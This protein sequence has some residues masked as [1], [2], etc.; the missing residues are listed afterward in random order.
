MSERNTVLCNIAMLDMRRADAD[1]LGQIKRIENAALLVMNESTDLSG[2]ELLNC[3]TTVR[4]PDGA[5]LRQVNGDATVSAGDE[6]SDVY[7]MVNG[8]LMINPDVT[9]EMVRSRYVGMMVNGQVMCPR[10]VGAAL[11]A[12]GARVNGQTR[13]YPDGAILR[14]GERFEL[15]AD[16]AR[17]MEP[18]LYV[19]DGLKALD[20]QA[21][22]TARER[23]VSFFTER[24]L[25]AQKLKSEVMELMRECS[26][27][28]TLVPEGFEHVEGLDEI[29]RLRAR[30]LR[31]RVFAEGSVRL[32]REVTGK[33]L[34]ALKAL[35][36]SGELTL[37]SAQL[38]ALADV[39]LDC[40][41]LRLKDDNE[42]V[43]QGDFEL[44][45]AAL[46]ALDGQRRLEV[47]GDL[48]IDEDVTAQLLRDKFSSVQLNGDVIAPKAL[49]A[50]LP[51]LGEVNGDL[52]DPATAAAPSIPEPVKEPDAG[53]EG[54]IY[55]ENMALYTM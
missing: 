27:A 39:D 17:L 41:K 50:I 46:E 36:V 29:D 14:L 51:V 5:A 1:K 18:G 28:F 53:E 31:G 52:I 37:T 10:S 44:S 34:A 24:V 38:D 7:L 12:L 20:T 9:P 3:A 47:N 54:M 11:E 33:D 40:L 13:L 21:V 32:S 35:H 30:R 15:D 25:C 43:V 26:P 22:A 8:K 42:M 4:L 49:W 2:I 16:A 19:V 23:G 55:I 45:A 48:I 6:Q